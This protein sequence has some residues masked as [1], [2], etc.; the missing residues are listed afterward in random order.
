MERY[1]IPNHQ[2]WTAKLLVQ[3]REEFGAVQPGKGLWLGKAEQVT[4]W[5]DGAHHIL[6]GMALENP[7]FR[8]LSA[9]RVGSDSG[10]QEVKA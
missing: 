2:K 9:R 10:R 5:G 6:V 3:V 4:S 8:P 7:Q 1:L